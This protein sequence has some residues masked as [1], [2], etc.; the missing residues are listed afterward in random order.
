MFQKPASIKGHLIPS[1]NR[2]NIGDSG[3]THVHRPDCARQEHRTPAARLREVHAEQT[4]LRAEIAGLRAHFTQHLSG[5]QVALEAMIEA[6]LAAFSAA[7]DARFEATH[8][9]MATNLEL[10]LAE[11]KKLGR[12]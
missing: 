4:S 1:A 7:M 12:G 11:V 5:L 3:P 10:V 2:E 8:R 6:R 9:Q